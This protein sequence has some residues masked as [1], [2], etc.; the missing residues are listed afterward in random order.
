M[1][2]LYE[3]IEHEYSQGENYLIRKNNNQ[4][5]LCYIYCSSNALYK[6]DDAAA[7]RQCIIENDRYEWMNMR[8]SIKPECEI[9]IRDIWLSWYVKGINANINSYEKLIAFLKGITQGYIVRCV[10]ASSGGFIG[11]ILALE[12]GAECCYCFAGQFSL[13]NHFDHLKTNPFLREELELRGDGWFEYYRRLQKASTKIIYVLPEG[14]RQDMEQYDLVKA[15]DNVHTIRVDSPQHGVA[16]YPYGL[17]K[18]ISADAAK[19]KSLTD[20]V[21][22][23]LRLSIKFGGL[24]NCIRYYAGKCIKKAI[25][26]KRK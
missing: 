23:K 17:S 19:L 10:G 7:F 20:V 18:F 5:G 22:N 8:A 25:K 11:N 12:L 9:F 16:L 1:Q 2:T 13:R 15:F 24:L 26:K 6:K 4:N 14:S 21:H 3:L